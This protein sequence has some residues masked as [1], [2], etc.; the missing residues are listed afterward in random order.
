MLH[1][2]SYSTAFVVGKQHRGLQR[3]S[4]RSGPLFLTNWRNTFVTARNPMFYSHPSFVHSYR[5]VHRGGRV[6]FS[7]VAMGDA[8]DKTPFYKSAGFYF[9]LFLGAIG[10]YFYR[11]RNGGKNE[12]R[13]IYWIEHDRI[14]S[15]EEIHVLRKGN[16]EFTVNEYER[17]CKE[18]LEM[19]PSGRCSVRSFDQLV[20]VALKHLTPNFGEAKKNVWFKANR[21]GLYKGNYP[22]GEYFYLERVF[23]SA[24]DKARDVARREGGK[25]D[26][27]V[28]LLHLL[29]AMSLA[30]SPNEPM[31][32]RMLGLFDAFV[33]CTPQNDLSSEEEKNA[34]NLNNLPTVM[35]ALMLTHQIPT[36]KLIRQKKKWPVP[37][38]EK[39]NPINLTSGLLRDQEQSKLLHSWPLDPPVEVP[40]GF[41]DKVPG[42]FLDVLLENIR[43]F[44][45]DKK[46]SDDLDAG[47]KS[48]QTVL[49]VPSLPDER[50]LRFEEFADMCRSRRLCLWDMCRSLKAGAKAQESQ[51]NPNEEVVLSDL[52]EAEKQMLAM[53]EISSLMRETPIE[54][55]EADTFLGPRAGF[56]F[57]M[58]D[59]GLGYYTDTYSEALK[60]QV[61]KD[62]RE[63]TVNLKRGDLPVE[64]I[65]ASAFEGQRS[66]FVFKNGDQGLG[67]YTDTFSVK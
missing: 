61:E 67:Y 11:S 27:E 49:E 23:S 22:I 63:E 57:K 53:Q 16:H 59:Q 24:E 64:F 26:G 41:G 6:S 15:K 33:A 38:Y 5:Y 34:L 19:W 35:E 52:E 30:I 54:Y 60:A 66:G 39:M 45:D 48:Q 4:A 47:L 28:P 2:L 13:E 7:T 1:R 65:E 14:I 55:V 40:N 20:L 17:F 46:E 18:A 56:V 10:T 42:G 9:S 44:V 31:A 58:G 43:S 51:A 29:V 32:A 50:K 8:A 12:E 21:A 62:K 3:V 25:W 37:E 36:G